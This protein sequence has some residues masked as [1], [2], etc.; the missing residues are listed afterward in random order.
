MV[1]GAGDAEGE[2]E[3]GRSKEKDKVTLVTAP[4]CFMMP[5]RK[6]IRQDSTKRIH[7][8]PITLLGSGTNSRV[9]RKEER[10][11]NDHIPQQKNVKGI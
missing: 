2:E 4:V 6:Y 5:Q 10:W 7:F 11:G 9:G 8:P 3:A 1:T